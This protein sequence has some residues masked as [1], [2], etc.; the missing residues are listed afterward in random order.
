MTTAGYFDDR[1][2]RVTIVVALFFCAANFSQLGGQDQTDS[3][4]QQSNPFLPAG[5]DDPGWRFLRGPTFDGH[6]PEIN[7]ADSWPSEGPPVLWTR[8]LGAGYSGFVADR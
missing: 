8:E 3:P 2:A 6:S 7:L 1:T 5:A 4:S